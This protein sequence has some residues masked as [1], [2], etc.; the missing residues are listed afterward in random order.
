MK[1]SLSTL[2]IP[3]GSNPA[4]VSPALPG[5]AMIGMRRG[6]GRRVRGSTWLRLRVAWLEGAHNDFAAQV[7]ARTADKEPITKRPPAT[8]NRRR[9]SQAGA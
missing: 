4:S 1:I 2:A 9:E 3:A 5:P 7:S 6:A 8:A